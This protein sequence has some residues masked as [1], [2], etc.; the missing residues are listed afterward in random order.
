MR[1]RPW[2]AAPPLLA[3]VLLPAAAG[4][5]VRAGAEFR[6]NTYTPGYQYSRV[7][8]AAASTDGRFVVVW[9]SGGQDGSGYAV[10]AGRF[11]ANGTRLGADFVVNTYTTANQGVA[12]VAV[13]P[14]GRFVV[15][16]QSEPVPGSPV[17]G[18]DGSASGV[19]AQRFDRQGLRSG[20]ELRV[21]T[22]TSDQQSRASV[23]MDP[24]GAFVVAWR[25][26]SNFQPQ[27]GDL[28]GVFGQRFSN[29][30][31]ALGA[32]FQVNTYT[33]SYQNRA[34]VGR[35][36]DGSFVVAW[37]SYNQEGAT[38]G[39]GIYARRYAS[40]GSAIGSDFRVNTYTTGDQA[41][42]SVGVDA[43]GN[44]VVAWMDYTA[45]DG[46]GTSIWAQRY[47][48][49][50]AP[51]GGE[52]Q[53]NSYTTGYQ[54]WPQVGMA[55]DGGAFVVAWG[56]FPRDGSGSGIFGR[57]FNSAGTAVGAE[58]QANSYVTGAQYN[59]SVG[60]DPSGN[61]T[62]AWT[63]GAQDGSFSG[64]YAQRFGGLVPA[65]LNVDTVVVAGQQN[66][67]KVWEPG[68]TA[69]MRPSWRNVNGA[70]QTFTATLSNITGPAGATYTITNS[71]GDY[72][73]VPNGTVGACTNCY[74]V[75][76][77]NPT[78]R[79]AFHWDASALE[80]LSPSNLGQQKRWALHI[81]G[82]F[83]DVPQTNVFYRFIE[84][85]LHYQV[86]GGCNATDYCPASVTTRDQMSVFVL[87]AKEGAGYTPPAC[88]TPV[89]PD[90]P[91]S[92]PFCRFIEELF[93]RGVVGGCGGGNYCPSQPVTR[94]QMAVFVL[95]TLDP[96]LNPPGCSGVVMFADV[97]QTSVFCKWIEEL[98]R[99]GVVTGCG[100][101]NYCPSQSVTREQMGVF[102]S[103]TFGLN[104]YG[105]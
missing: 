34:D 105:P 18:Q 52:F 23:A 30:A 79:P 4:A 36:A 26:A 78:S 48:P 81:G 17:P 57:K 54:Y 67:N 97:P 84:T 22:F 13:N 3:L 65:A 11:D 33:T 87:V 27:D 66:G 101:G 98:A 38:S 46:S 75:M 56:D 16:W 53:V 89:F 39:Y 55:A 1:G 80:T 88:G 24:G 68:E 45:R 43:A 104:L 71:T 6:V 61:F 31:A 85:L 28:S 29:A 44:F 15:A 72:G 50:G 73:T 59:A 14:A 49:A 102:I 20:A 32:E 2:R 19:F 21:N 93:R 86:T 95:R 51:V 76:V 41:Y 63:S 47:S 74:A 35:A 25:S 7:N 8:A 96:T 100:G 103:A 40:D 77:N 99:R 83:A 94:E 69:D 42:P 64:V 60:M 10:M 62:V 82:S 91:A 92:S 70:S 37:H 90:V 58:F 12:A 5:Q 9:E